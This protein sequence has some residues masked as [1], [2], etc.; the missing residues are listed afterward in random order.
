VWLAEQCSSLKAQNN[1][2]MCLQWLR[3][4]TDVGG[5]VPIQNH[6]LMSNNF[7]LLREG[8]KLCVALRSVVE[9]ASRDFMSSWLSVQAQQLVINDPI[10]VLLCH[11]KV[12]FCNI[13]QVCQTESGTNNLK[14]YCSD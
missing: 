3:E 8:F 6:F 5:F 11:I 12:T 1:P 7:G 14:F 9:I 10:F 4:F 13:E 2:A